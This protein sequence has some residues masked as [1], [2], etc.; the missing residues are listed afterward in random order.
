MAP[1]RIA[2]L[3]QLVWDQQTIA[4]VVYRTTDG[5]RLS[6]ESPEAVMLTEGFDLRPRA[7]ARAKALREALKRRGWREAG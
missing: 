7:L 4:C 2:T 5:M 6:I 1:V 3:W